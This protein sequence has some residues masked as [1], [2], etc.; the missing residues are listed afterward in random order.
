M[1]VLDKLLERDIFV[2]AQVFSSLSIDQVKQLE[3]KIDDMSDDE[4]ET[5]LNMG[6]VE[7]IRSYTK[8]PSKRTF[9]DFVRHFQK[10]LEAISA[11]LRNRGQLSSVQSI[12]HLKKDMQATFIGL[13]W[14]K[15][16]TKSGHMMLTIEDRT[17]M[18]RVIVTKRN[19]ELFSRVKN[20]VLDEVV[21][22]SGLC[23]GDVVFANDIIVPDIPV[24]NSLKKAP[25]DARAIFISDLHFGNKDF[26]YKEFDIFLDWLNGNVGN[27]ESREV[28]SKVKYLFIAGDLIEGVGIYPSQ[29]D[30]LAIVDIK[31]Q[32][33]EFS[34]YL[35]KIPKHIQ[36]IMCPGN[37]EAGRLAEPQFD[38]YSDFTDD[39]LEKPNVHMVSNPSN[40]RIHKSADFEGF[41]VLLYHGYS[42]IYYGNNV[43][44]IFEK[45]GTNDPVAIMKYLM[46]KRHLAPTHTS[47]LY[48]P[49]PEG[50]PLV[51][52]EVPDFFISGHTHK[53]MYE[54]Y[55]GITMINCSC[56]VPETENQRNYGV[57]PEVAIVPV[58][59]LQTREVT[60]MDFNE[61]TK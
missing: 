10:R 55:K 6:S 26:H 5:F 17:G 25:D 20:L 2:E 12:S 28:A 15:Q 41:N 27:A 9:Q 19:E 47:N 50:D 1:N 40:V 52:H 56:W 61:V 24:T 4:I 33:K 44:S 49:D 53:A 11:M 43:Q 7:I 8:K 59:N 35:D 54:N 21:G 23:A 22:V 39:L 37:H 60:M 29:E 32:Y 31:D 34:K 42:F 16:E 14:D 51:I 30:D 46:Q 36:V 38:L 45:G 58:V 57:S 18:I 48:I 13:I 3:N